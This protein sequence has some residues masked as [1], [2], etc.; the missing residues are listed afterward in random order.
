MVHLGTAFLY[1]IAIIFGGVY[2]GLAGAI[3]SAFFD[4]MMGFSSLYVM[5]L[6]Y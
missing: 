4:M 5:V 6:F 3:G 2:A 1:T